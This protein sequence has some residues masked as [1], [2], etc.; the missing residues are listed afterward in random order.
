MPKEGSEDGPDLEKLESL[1]KTL[2]K[3][4]DGIWLRKLSR[5]SSIAPSTVHYYLEE[6][7]DSFVESKGAKDGEGKYFGIRL[8]KLKE[9]IRNQLESGKP[10]EYLLKTRD[11]LT[12]S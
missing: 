11:I 1:I 6:V 2:R 3:Y 9:G 5:E 4:P 12:D 10:V 7:V 8:I